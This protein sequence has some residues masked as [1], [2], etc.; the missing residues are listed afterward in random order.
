MGSVDDVGE[1]WQQRAPLGGWRTVDGTM[2]GNG[3]VVVEQTCL[4]LLYLVVD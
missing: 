4:S 2:C 1:G 3:G